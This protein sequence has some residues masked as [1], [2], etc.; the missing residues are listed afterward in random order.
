MAREGL[1]FWGLGEQAHQWQDDSKAPQ[2][3]RGRAAEGRLLEEDG[4][5]LGLRGQ[6]TSMQ[7]HGPGPQAVGPAGAERASGQ[8]SRAGALRKH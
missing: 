8:Q 1:F 4:S 2:V 5:G 3:M 6:R 7:E